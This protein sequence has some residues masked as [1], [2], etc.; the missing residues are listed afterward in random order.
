[1]RRRGW[2]RREELLDLIGATNLIPGPNSTE[3]AIHI[4]HRRAGAAGLMVAGVAFI[5][6][7]MLT[8][9]ALAWAY[10]RW[11]RLPEA[12]W[13]LDG[14]KPVIIA[15]VAQALV[16]FARTA[17]KGAWH[18]LV[19]AAA[20]VA[21][22]LGVH[23]LLVLAGGGALMLAAALARRPRPAAPRALVP[24]A[25]WLAPAAASAV[26]PKAALAPLFFFFF[27]KVGAVAT[28]SAACRARWWPRSGSSC[29]P[30]SS[31]RCRRRWC[32]GCGARPRPAR[33]STA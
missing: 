29:P 27:L 1:M 20:A 12:G 25:G 15:V 9:G 3:L 7:A 14:V 10:V 11:G 26:A 6:P 2:M 28:S 16:R 24:W 22:A 30:S 23:E 21:S 31:W 33:C 4:G 17:V 5:A 13:L 32:R 18:A 8:V 19:A